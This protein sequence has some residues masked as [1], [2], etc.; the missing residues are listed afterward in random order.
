VDDKV[1]AQAKKKDT[2]D[3]V[4]TVEEMALEFQKVGGL[5]RAACVLLY[6]SLDAVAVA[7]AIAVAVPEGW[8]RGCGSRAAHV[9]LYASLDAVTVAVAVAVA[10]SGGRRGCGGRAACVPRVVAAVADLRC[11]LALMTPITSKQGMNR[12][13]QLRPT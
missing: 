12:T 7:V 1:A 13:K 3:P 6:A 2:E 9:L 4:F 10:V 8:R 11:T 5:G